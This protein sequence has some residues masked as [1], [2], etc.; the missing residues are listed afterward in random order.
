MPIQKLNMISFFAVGSYRH[1]TFSCG[2]LDQRVYE[3]EEFNPYFKVSIQ[4]FRICTP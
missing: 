1:N 4:S 3:G 2:M